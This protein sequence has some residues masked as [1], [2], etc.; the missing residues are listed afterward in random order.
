M[1]EEIVSDEESA[2]TPGKPLIGGRRESRERAVHLL[3]EAE[4]KATDPVA[5]AAAQIVSPDRYT[6]DIVKGV[7]NARTRLDE[8]IETYADGWTI[9]RMPVMDVVVLRVAVLELLERD[10]VP[11][12]VVLSEA[13]ELASQY[14]TDESP[15]FVNGLLAAIAD[16]VRPVDAE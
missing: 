13:V 4:M 15:R 11:R 6:A 2:T 9:K 1:P 3:Y 5:V 8:L 12:G 16:Q 7:A 14:G 10:D